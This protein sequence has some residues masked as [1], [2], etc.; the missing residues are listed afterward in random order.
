MRKAT[1]SGNKALNMLAINQARE[2]SH[3]TEEES[4]GKTGNGSINTRKPEE[5]HMQEAMLLHLRA[6]ARGMCSVCMPPLSQP[7]STRNATAK[8]SSMQ[9]VSLSS[10]K[11]KLHPP[12][13]SPRR[14][15]VGCPFLVKT[16]MDAYTPM[17]A[18]PIRQY[19]R[20]LAPS[21]WH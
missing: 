2:R 12:L 19:Q 15:R 20:A 13:R 16:A 5:A 9:R 18:G 10:F 14:L 21:A 3:W 1:E 8:P 11:L 7:S 17:A 6:V 4:K